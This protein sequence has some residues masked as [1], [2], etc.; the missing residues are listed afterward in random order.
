MLWRRKIS[1]QMVM[2]RKSQN[3]ILI[4]STFN[5]HNFDYLSIFLRKPCQ[6]TFHCLS[7][8]LVTSKAKDNSFFFLHMWNSSLAHHQ[9]VFCQN[10]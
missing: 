7:Q 9:V 5:L 10:I 4:M 1:T 3:L 6:L 2:S 8:K